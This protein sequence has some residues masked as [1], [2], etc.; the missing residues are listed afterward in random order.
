MDLTLIGQILTYIGTFLGGGWLINLYKA[1]PEKER[2]E[3][4]N[5]RDAMEIQKDLI[6]SL[7]KRVDSLSRE[8]S[9]LN[10]RVDVKHEIIYSAYGCRLVKTPDD[11]IVIKNYNEKCLACELNEAFNSEKD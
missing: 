2:L 9:V 5:V 4:N 3:L 11:C 6:T 7:D 1:R 10:H 8:I